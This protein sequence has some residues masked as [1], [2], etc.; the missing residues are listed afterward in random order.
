MLSHATGYAQPNMR[1]RSL[2]WLL[3]LISAPFPD[4]LNESPQR[5]ILGTHVFI[6]LCWAGARFGSRHTITSPCHA[7][8]GFLRFPAISG[9]PH[10]TWPRS[11]HSQKLPQASPPVSGV[12]ASCHDVPT[13][14]CSGFSG[15]NVLTARAVAL[16]HWVVIIFFSILCL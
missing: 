14:F 1:A 8:L 2:L 11:S 7:V 13:E 9:L 5:R 10:T 12:R 4:F 16:E 6:Y 3:T 15:R